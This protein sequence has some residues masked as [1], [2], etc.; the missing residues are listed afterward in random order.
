M[1]KF[2]FIIFFPFK[3]FLALQGSVKNRSDKFKT[4]ESLS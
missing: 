3:K 2:Y 4:H 1:L